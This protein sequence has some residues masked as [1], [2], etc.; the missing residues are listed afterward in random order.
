M[1]AYSWI[2]AAVKVL[3]TAALAQGV[4]GSTLGSEINTL[5]SG[6]PVPQEDLGFNS[7][8]DRRARAE[9]L[10]PEKLLAALEACVDDL[11]LLRIDGDAR[12]NLTVLRHA[13]KT[14]GVPI[15]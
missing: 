1:S 10:G 3:K 11:Q 2:N 8:A 9:K 6:V 15:E 13:Q 7:P 4:P 14:L 12:P 5:L